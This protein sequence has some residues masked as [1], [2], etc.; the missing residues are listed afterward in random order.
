VSV[1]L[2]TAAARR[3]NSIA[4]P[5][6]GTGIMGFPKAKVA[7]IMFDE[8]LSFSSRIKLQS[9]QE[10]HLVLHPSDAESI[11]VK[12]TA[13]SQNKV[14]SVTSPAPGVHEMVIRSVICQVKVG[15]I[16]KEDADIIV[17]SSNHTFNQYAGI[18]TALYTNPA[19][20]CTQPN[21]RFILTQNGN[22]QC[23]RILHIYIKKTAADVKR[24]VCDVLQECEAQQFTSVAFPALG[25]GAARL[26]AAAVAD[27]MLDALLEFATSSSVRHV[28]KV[29]VIVFQQTMVNDFS[30]SM[31]KKAASAIWNHITSSK[32]KTPQRFLELKDNTEPVI[33]HLCGESQKSVKEASSWLQKLVLKDQSENSIKNDWIKDFGEQEIEELRGLQKGS[34]VTISLDIHESKVT[35][36]GLTRD[37]LSMT[38]KIQTLIDNLRDQK[39]REREAELCSNMVEWRY[40]DGLES[41]PVDIMTNLELENAKTE[42][43]G[44]FMISIK[45][46]KYTVNMELKSAKRAGGVMGN[47]HFISLSEQSVDLPAHWDSMDNHTVKMVSLSPV[48]QEYNN[49]IQQ[50]MRTCQMRII[51]IER[52]QNSPLWLNYKIKKQSID[53]R[54]GNA[55]NEKQLFHGTDPNTILHVNHNGFNR[56]YAGKNAAS[57]GNG[58]YFAVNA[59]Y[60]AHDRY[61]R[62]DSNGYKYMYLTR[63]ITG[64]YCVGTQGMVAP[65]AKNP[66]NTTDLYDSVTDNMAKPSMFVIFNDIQAYPEYLITF[67]K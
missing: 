47:T 37:V 64:V 20:M 32:E 34:H 9:L 15:D 1:C 30:S 38:N 52:I 33:F 58:T 17:N 35:V 4:F 43:K 67:S 14:T 44:S 61:S 60:S 53:S 62:P 39:T 18:A 48:S 49:V 59:M 10:V 40:N 45:G 36:S 11:K 2:N 46:V 22:L 8:I 7:A 27:A 54:N 16:T 6:I 23:K 3:M 24:A 26:P 12:H 56:S 42:N 50:F 57:Y 13:N 55:N 66:S 41:R 5:A 29:K 19:C 65:P 21:K 51:K 28:Q 63:V 31:T 25:T